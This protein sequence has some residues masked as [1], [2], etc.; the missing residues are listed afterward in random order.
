MVHSE[1]KMTRP[2]SAS[3]SKQQ[4]LNGNADIQETNQKRV[5]CCLTI[6]IRAAMSC[7]H[8]R[9]PFCTAVPASPSLP[10]QRVH[11]LLILLR[12]SLR[13]YADVLPQLMLVG[14]QF[15]SGEPGEMLVGS[16]GHWPGP[17]SKERCVIMCLCHGSVSSCKPLRCRCDIPSQGSHVV[18]FF[19]R[20]QTQFWWEPNWAS[21]IS[22]T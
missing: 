13:L 5:S 17:G 21:G 11:P 22:P 8:L 7:V 18:S 6:S 16:G 9:L 4:L 20:I 3:A 10:C 19:P 1:A 12:P 2:D 14:V 15:W